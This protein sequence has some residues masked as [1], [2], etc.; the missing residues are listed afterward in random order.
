MYLGWVLIGGFIGFVF[1]LLARDDY[2]DR[3][4][5]KRRTELRADIGW[6]VV[7]R[8]D[9][10]TFQGRT[11][12]ISARG[13]LLCSQE[14]LSLSMNEIVSLTL[15]PPIRYPLEITAEVIRANIHCGEDHGPLRGTAVRFVIIS[16]GDR[17]FL[18]SSVFDQLQGKDRSARKRNTSDS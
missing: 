10:S 17:Q 3:Q 1:L 9:D 16:E 15:K 18:C 5:K 12:N 11:I 14:Q 13:A 8:K 2:H 4:E 6:P 7:I